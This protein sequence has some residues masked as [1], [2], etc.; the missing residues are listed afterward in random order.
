MRGSG[1]LVEDLRHDLEE[2]NGVIN[3]LERASQELTTIIGWDEAVRKNPLR[4]RQLSSIGERLEIARGRQSS[5]ARTIE[6]L[7]VRS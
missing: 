6:Q 7:E 3:I 2:T 5:I 1:P 4:Q